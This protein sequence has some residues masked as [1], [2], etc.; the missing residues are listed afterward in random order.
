MPAAVEN[1]VT[2]ITPALK[3]KYPNKTDAE[4]TQ[5]G[6]GICTKMYKEGKLNDDG[7]STIDTGDL[8][9]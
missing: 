3:R 6:W 4:I 2:K 7:T 8:K 9:W 1:C 5:M